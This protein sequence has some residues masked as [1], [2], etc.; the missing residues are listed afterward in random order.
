MA[1]SVIRAQQDSATVEMLK[2]IN[3]ILDYCATYPDDGIVYRS[4]DMILNA[5]SD[6]GF[7]NKTKSR[8]IAGAYIFLSKI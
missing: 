6:A 2:A 1:L 3:Q 7:N 5:H 4:S 8:S